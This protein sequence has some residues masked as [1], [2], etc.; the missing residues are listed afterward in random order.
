MKASVLSDP[1]HLALGPRRR[2]CRGRYGRRGVAGRRRRDEGVAASAQSTSLASVVFENVSVSDPKMATAQ[3]AMPSQLWPSGCVTKAMTGPNEVTVTFDDC[4]GPFGLV[5][6]DGQETV[7]LGTAPGGVLQATIEGV[8]LTANGKPVHHSATAVITFPTSTTRAVTWNGSWQRTNDTG[9]LV[10]H[11]SDLSISIDLSTGCRTME[12]AAQ[13]HVDAREVNTT[14]RGYE[15]CQAPSGQEGC[16]S[17]A[18]NHVG[19]TS[20]KT[21]SDPVRRHGRGRGDRPEGR[22]VPGAAGLYA[23]PDPRLSGAAGVDG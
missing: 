22:H 12:G 8:N 21:V 19:V 14:I 1:R 15:S 2:L 11:T 20:G 4:T 10:Q 18:V 16:P 5:H 13:T 17:G 6:I 3:L 7:S 23:A 9:E